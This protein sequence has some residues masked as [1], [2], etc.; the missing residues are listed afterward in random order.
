MSK[1]IDNYYLQLDAQ[2]IMYIEEKLILLSYT[3]V[4]KW[5]QVNYMR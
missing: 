5:P 3:D 2:Y 1:Y 4:W